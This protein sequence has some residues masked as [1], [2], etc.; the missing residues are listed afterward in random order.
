MRI[1]NETAI[2]LFFCLGVFIALCGCI[3]PITNIIHA[4]SGPPVVTGHVFLDGKAI[5]GAAVDAVSANGTY[6]RYAVTGN[7]GVYTFNI[8]PDTDYNVTATYQGLQHTIWPVYLPGDTSTFDINLTTLPMSTIEGSGY[9]TI[10][11]SPWESKEGRYK[12]YYHTRWSGFLINARSMKD[13]TTL[14]AVTDING[15]YILK[16]EPDTVCVISSYFFPPDGHPIASFHY[17]NSG[18]LEYVD[19]G[20]IT[21]GP[22][23]IAGP[24][25]T[26]F[27]DYIFPMP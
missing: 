18:G 14:T 19:S 27:V 4:P 21:T 22:I 3:D 2:A 23:A 1:R 25:E 12:T 9:T 15:S 17:R 7:D 5:S 8:T 20:N 6:H 13:N 16:I 26:V 10:S 24:N 11:V